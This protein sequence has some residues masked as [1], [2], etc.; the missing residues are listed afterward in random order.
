MSRGLGD[1]IVEFLHSQSR[2]SEIIACAKGFADRGYEVSL[3]GDSGWM[4]VR[5]RGA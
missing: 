3:D 4:Y 2:I 1:P 5:R